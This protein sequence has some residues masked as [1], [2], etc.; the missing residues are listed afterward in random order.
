LPKEKENGVL[1]FHS[2][3]LEQSVEVPNQPKLGDLMEVLKA[4]REQLLTADG[5][6]FLVA[7]LLMFES[8][9]LYPV[10]AD[11]EN[12]ILCC[13]LPKGPDQLIAMLSG[14]H[15]GDL[16]DLLQDGKNGVLR[17]LL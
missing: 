8:A 15:S 11:K 4:G 2:T 17:F 10:L 14:F 3:S 1:A 5:V 7:V 12:E 6:K 13:L 9:D 16:D